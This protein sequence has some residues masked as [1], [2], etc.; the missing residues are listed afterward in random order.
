MKKFTIVWQPLERT[1]TET[2]IVMAIGVDDALLSI[3]EEARILSITW[4][5]AK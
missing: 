3:P 5:S 4:E 1:S 2:S